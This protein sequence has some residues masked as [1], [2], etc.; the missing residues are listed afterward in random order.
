[1]PNLLKIH[2]DV[3]TGRDLE[4]IANN[5]R[6]VTLASITLESSLTVAEAR[7]IAKHWQSIELF[8][9]LRWENKK[10][11]PV[12]D[13]AVALD[14][15]NKCKMLLQ[16]KLAPSDAAPY[17]PGDYFYSRVIYGMKSAA[18]V[19]TDNTRSRLTELFVSSLSAQALATIVQKCV[20]LNTLHIVHPVPTE[21]EQMQQ[22]LLFTISA[23]RV[24]NRCS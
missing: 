3:Q 13:E 8:T 24:W 17:T 9:L 7:N 4:C 21:V 15:I 2:L 11:L 18:L 6:L 14:F 22:S 10:H 20:Y 19:K 1:M 12:C 16:L 5:C 23:V